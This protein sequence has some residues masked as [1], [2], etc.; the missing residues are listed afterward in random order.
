MGRIVGLAAGWRPAEPIGPAGLGCGGVVSRF[1]VTVCLPPVAAGEVRAALGAVMAPFDINGGGGNPQGEWDWW[2]IGAGGEEGFVVRP[3]YEGDPRLLYGEPWPGEEPS[4]RVPGCCDGGPRGLLD[5]AATRAAVAAR[6]GARWRAEREEFSRLAATCPPAEPRVVFWARH[7]ADPDAFPL[8][9]AVA[10]YLAQ[11]LLRALRDPAVLAPYPGLR[12]APG[13]LGSRIDPI[14]YYTRDLEA[15]ARREA[16][17]ALGAFALLTLEG[18]WT[19]AVSP[20][21]FAGGLP[22][23]DPAVAYFRLSGE[24]LEL[25]EENCVVVRLLCH[26]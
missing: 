5:F 10:D 25:L 26:C 16:A 3:G 4:G 14:A 2:R 19:S 11:P 23:E 6:A 21:S 8:E 13:L 12:R 22:G 7:R 20:G 1:V 15:D 24:Y 9:R 18:E 17:G